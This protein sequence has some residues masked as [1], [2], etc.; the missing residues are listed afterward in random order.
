MYVFYYQSYERLLRNLVII[1]AFKQIFWNVLEY[2]LLKCKVG[3]KITK[4]ERLFDER[5]QV[6]INNTE[7]D[8]LKLELEDL[9]LHREIERQLQMQPAPETLVYFYNEAVIQMGFIAFFAVVFPFAPLFSFLT[10]LL[11]VVIKLKTFAEY[12]KRNLAQCASGAGNWMSITSFIT[13]FAIP[14]N[15]AILLYARKPADE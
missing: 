4:V 10:N 11:E 6:V 13:Y 12:G 8:Q 2:T 15:L 3:R 7:A 9:R 14:I 5:R 1:M